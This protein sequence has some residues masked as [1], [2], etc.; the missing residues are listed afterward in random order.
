MRELAVRCPARMKGRHRRGR[1]RR[2]ADV[3]VQG[4]QRPGRAAAISWLLAWLIDPVARPPQA[5]ARLPRPVRERCNRNQQQAGLPS[6][7]ARPA[8]R[9]RDRQLGR[10]S[11]RRCQS[12]AD[13]SVS[14]CSTTS[15]AG[16]PGVRSRR[17]GRAPG[18][19]SVPPARARSAPVG[20]ILLR[21]L[22]IGLGL[23]EQGRRNVLVGGRPAGPAA[24]APCP[25]FTLLK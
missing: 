12:H 6:T 25:R 21:W 24:G 19:G 20:G 7:G 17:C 2:R 10:W 15:K 1:A 9:W 3:R 18:W 8:H 22:V 11:R 16:A 13:E 14:A 4:A 5:H 23:P